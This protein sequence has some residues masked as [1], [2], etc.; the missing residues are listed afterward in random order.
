MK[1]SR[2]DFESSCNTYS[3]LISHQLKG[4]RYFLIFKKTNRNK[5]QKK[6]KGCKSL[7]NEQMSRMEVLVGRC[8]RQTQVTGIQEAESYLMAQRL[9]SGGRGRFLFTK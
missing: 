1:D 3:Q 2:L 9:R 6:Q 8:L 5:K 7:T 4:G